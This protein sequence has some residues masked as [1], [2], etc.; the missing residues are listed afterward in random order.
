MT[1]HG[2]SY[3]NVGTKVIN[4]YVSKYDDLFLQFTSMYRE[5]LREL[6]LRISHKFCCE[7]CNE[8]GLDK[9]GF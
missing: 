3:L 4:L 6:H 5:L 7:N 2:F 1:F 9:G 8:V